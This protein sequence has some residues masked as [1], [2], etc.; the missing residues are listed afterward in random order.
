MQT[1]K[2][3]RQMKGTCGK[4]QTAK[5][6]GVSSGIQKKLVYQKK[7]NW[8]SIASD[9]AKPTYERTSADPHYYTKE[10]FIESCRNNKLR[11]V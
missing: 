3:Q 6:C 7:E 8:M 11:Y 5:V 4:T 1:I 10:I 2:T 9:Q